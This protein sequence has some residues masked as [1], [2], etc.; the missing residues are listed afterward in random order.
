MWEEL[1]WFPINKSQKQMKQ[2][3]YAK[4][5]GTSYTNL[6]MRSSGPH[7]VL[8][9]SSTFRRGVRVSSSETG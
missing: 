2:H 3:V 6:G 9:E 4:T 7:P 1:K 8:G 5:K